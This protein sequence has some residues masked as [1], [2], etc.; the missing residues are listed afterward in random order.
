MLAFKDADIVTVKC[1]A[2]ISP[3]DGKSLN[4]CL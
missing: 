2:T 3:F 4:V 1:C